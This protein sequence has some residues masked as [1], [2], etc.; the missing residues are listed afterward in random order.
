MAYS[1]LS[2]GA[3]SNTSSSTTAASE[4]SPGSYIGNFGAADSNPRSQHLN[5]IDFVPQ[6]QCQMQMRNTSVCSELDKLSMGLGHG[7]TSE[8]SLSS[9]GMEICSPNKRVKFYLSDT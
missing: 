1:Q 4:V 7:N 6:R 9:M 2:L 3:A 8:R 5:A